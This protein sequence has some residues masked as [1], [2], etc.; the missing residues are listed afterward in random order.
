MRSTRTK[1]E[2]KRSV[3]RHEKQNEKPGEHEQEET[4]WRRAKNR[5]SI[6]ICSSKGKELLHVCAT[7]KE[8]ARAHIYKLLQVL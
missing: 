5:K 3:V 6:F 1:K 4:Q 7:A 8:K 2:R